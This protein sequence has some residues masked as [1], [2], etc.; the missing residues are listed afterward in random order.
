VALGHLL[1][2][3]NEL[4]RAEEHL[5]RGQELARAGGHHESL[6]NTGVALA[7]LR[8]AQGD[9]AGALA[10]LLEA[11]QALARAEMP[12]ASAELAAY[13]A[14][15]WIAQGDLA[16]AG[17]WAAEAAQR[18]GEDRGYTRQIEAV[19][20]ARVLL[21]QGQQGQ[22]LDQLAACQE[23]ADE[24]G[25]RGWAVEIGI[26]R[27]LAQEARGNR[28]GA[29]TA[30]GSALVQAEPE[31]YVQVFL[32]E[33]EPLAALLRRAAAL[34]ASP[35]FVARLLD[36]MA[37][38]ARAQG[39]AAAADASALVEPLTEREIEVLRLM[40]TGLSNREI[41]AELVVAMGTVKAHLHNVY[42]KLGVRTR[43]R[44]AARARELGLL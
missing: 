6:R 28:A 1:C 37:R 13:K 24:S 9:A 17:R 41:A 30:L 4:G 11:E 23:A 38:P 31:G 12:L 43:G 40:A 2:E 44:A 5:L 8:L 36:A 10:A 15:A 25:G 19:T 14:R 29:L 22:A 39:P 18:P 21:A 32:D 7:R 3:G 16:A 42:G 33:G 34:G 35:Q 27:A 20:L 26:L